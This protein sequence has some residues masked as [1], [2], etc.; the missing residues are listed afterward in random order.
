MIQF[1]TLCSQNKHFKSISTI[2]EGN[3]YAYFIQYVILNMV[4]NIVNSI[5]IVYIDRN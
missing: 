2:K 3:L 4:N 5:R 1:N